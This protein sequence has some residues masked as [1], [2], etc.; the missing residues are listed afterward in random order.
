MA[1]GLLDVDNVTA[2]V[3]DSRTVQ[4]ICGTN[5]TPVTHQPPNLEIY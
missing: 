5:A 2:A 3:A 1:V 4:Q